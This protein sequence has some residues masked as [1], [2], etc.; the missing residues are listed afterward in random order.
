MK[1]TDKKVLGMKN[2]VE[3]KIG[4]AFEDS[5]QVLFIKISEESGFDVINNVRVRFQFDESVFPR[6][7]EIIFN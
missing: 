7:A 3:L 5:E 4:D 1:W 2:F 6:D